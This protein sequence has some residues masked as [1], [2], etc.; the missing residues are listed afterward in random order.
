MNIFKCKK[1]KNNVNLKKELY[2]KLLIFI[3]LVLLIIITSFNTGR[4]FYILKNTYLEN[5]KGEINSGVARWNFSAR[6]IT[7]NEVQKD[8]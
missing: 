1:I 6:I 5:S 8:E 3:I 7:G 2:I 4:K